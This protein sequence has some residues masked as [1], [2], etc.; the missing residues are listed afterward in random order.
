MLSRNRWWGSGEREVAMAS[1]CF[2]ELRAFGSFDDAATD[3][4][5]FEVSYVHGPLDGLDGVGYGYSSGMISRLEKRLGV[6]YV[7][8]WL[9]S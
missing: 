6:S 3:S 8:S 9:P 1:R 5:S 4:T 7:M 2:G